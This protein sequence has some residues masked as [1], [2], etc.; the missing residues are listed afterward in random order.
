MIIEFKPEKVGLRK[1]KSHVIS[2]RG[3]DN[4]IWRITLV[5]GLN[6]LSPTQSEQLQSYP[7][8]DRYTQK[9]AIIIRDRPDSDFGRK[10]ELESLYDSQGYTPIS[11]LAAKYGIKKPS[12]GWKDAIPLIVE[13]ESEMGTDEE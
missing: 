5:P 13:Y 6:D 11:N 9:D 10:A 7:D 4:L 8:L 12:G 2:A 1:D 3:D